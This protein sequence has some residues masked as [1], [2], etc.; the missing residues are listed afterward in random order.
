MTKAESPSE[1]LFAGNYVGNVRTAQVRGTLGS[2]HPGR[3]ADFR[4]I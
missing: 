3:F 4:T 1:F 2:L